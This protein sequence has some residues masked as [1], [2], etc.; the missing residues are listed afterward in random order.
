MRIHM[1]IHLL[2]GA[3]I[4]VP[5]EL[6]AQSNYQLV[7]DVPPAP[8][9]Y[10]W[11]AIQNPSGSQWILG[12]TGSA[13]SAIHKFDA[14]GI[15]VWSQGY[16]SPT[17]F[18]VITNTIPDGADGAYCLRQGG[19]VQLNG[20]NDI[21]TMVY[22]YQ[23]AHL[24]GSGAVDW[25]RDI[26][27]K[28][29]FV[30]MSS[31]AHKVLARFSDG[32]LGL[33]VVFLDSP[34]HERWSLSRF[35]ASGDLEWSRQIGNE[36]VSGLSMLNTMQSDPPTLQDDGSSGIFVIGTR[37]SDPF[38]TTL[39]LHLSPAG[40]VDW[41]N[42]YD[43]EGQHDFSNCL[44]GGLLADGSLATIGHIATNSGTYCLTHR[45]EIDGTVTRSDLV[46]GSP[47][48]E[49]CIKPGSDD[50]MVLMVG[51]GIGGGPHVMVISPTGEVLVSN[52]RRR[53]TLDPDYIFMEN[54]GM[55]LSGN[56]LTLGGNLRYQDIILSTA[57]YR[58][59][60][61]RLDVFG[62]ANDC[63]WEALPVEHFEVPNNLVSTTA[64]P[65]FVED[66]TSLTSSSP[67]SWTVEALPNPS[68][69]ELCSV[70][71]GI[72]E[73]ALDN[74]PLV[75]RNVV[76]QGEEVLLDCSEAGNI[77]V[78]DYQGR[79]VISEGTT[80]PARTT[81]RTTHLIAGGYQVRW[82]SSKGDHVKQGRFIVL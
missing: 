74:G 29:R 25:A 57:E 3:L 71:V 1:G 56:T 47:F 65:P 28:D 26:T 18:S 68:T 64:I 6:A 27:L 41:M 80:Q 38:E 33:L 59:A 31:C 72:M 21:D 42:E 32:S 62:T 17:S 20:S 55:G 24:T 67:G 13:S 19:S 7:L 9:P 75:L 39:V 54:A 36:T 79:L 30:Q 2:L 45:I 10:V 58:P 35:S 50:N 81:L 61:E 15:A 69:I 4:C 44:A 76:E 78:F 12:S 82:V 37:G 60:L 14:N 48:H 73:G 63:M 22:A 23:L 70:T 53:S 34:W 40:D 52:K 66:V 5:A 16:T 8:S 77:M 51:L 11:N 43:Y 46:T 49:A